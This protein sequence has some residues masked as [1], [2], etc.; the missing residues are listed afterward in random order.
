MNED[1]IY[2]Q[3]TYDKIM[4]CSYLGFPD[5]H[6]VLR[7]VSMSGNKNRSDK[8]KNYFLL[9]GDYSSRLK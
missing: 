5:R 2:R 9:K 3:Y 6:N 4:H 1:E 8:N 7:N